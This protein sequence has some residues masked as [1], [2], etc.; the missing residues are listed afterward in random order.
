MA[1]I[2]ITKNKEGRQHVYLVEGYREDGKVKQ[3]IIHK[4]G[5]LDELE[6]QEPGIL[7]RLKRE[8]K[9]NS[10]IDPENLTIKYSLNAPMNRPDLHFGWK[11]LNDL[12]VTLKLDRYFSSHQLEK[13]DTNLS[14]VAKLL[15][16]QRILKP[17]SKH[18]T[19]ISQQ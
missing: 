12:Y 17:N 15:I 13:S 1:F 19:F 18:K 14:Q 7:E 16:F 11:I 5:L 6:A 3:R 10:H 2:R 9:E 4:Y 8:A